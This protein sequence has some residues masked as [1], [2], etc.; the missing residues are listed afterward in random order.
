VT[1]WDSLRAAGVT[2][3]I[4]GP[5]LADSASGRLSDDRTDERIRWWAERMLEEA[6]ATIDV[7]GREHVPAGES[8]VLMSN[9]RSYFDIPSVY[10]AVARRIRMVAKKE[11]FRVPLFGSAMRVAGFIE[12]DRGARDAAVASLRRGESLL[13]GGAC[14]WIAPEGTRTKTGKLGP[15]KSGGFH[16]ALDA[17]VRILPIAIR[18]TEAVMSADSFEV[19]RGAK[20][21]VKI[22]PPVDAPSYGLGRR[23]E[24][25]ADVRRVIAEALGE[26]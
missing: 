13:R 6:E 11:L 1:Y 3:R 8:L 20:V 12:V 23:K 25:T 17:G 22:L 15:F 4:I 24:L 26:T 21:S 14:V 9:H 19:R 10:V 18:G 2:L 16:L 5:T 7:E